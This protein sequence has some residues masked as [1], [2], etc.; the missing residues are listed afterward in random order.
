LRSLSGSKEEIKSHLETKGMVKGG[1]VQKGSVDLVISVA[2][3]VGIGDSQVVRD[4]SDDVITSLTFVGTSTRA[5]NSATR[6][7]LEGRTEQRGLTRLLYQVF[8]TT[9]LRTRLRYKPRVKK[10]RCLRLIHWSIFFDP[11]SVRYVRVLIN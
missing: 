6:Q 9:S 8:R 11:G 4:P 7:T 3:D 5:H 1:K 2:T 10:P